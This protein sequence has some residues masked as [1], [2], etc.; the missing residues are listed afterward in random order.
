[1]QADRAAVQK[2]GEEYDEAADREQFRA[3][4]DAGKHGEQDQQQRAES[5]RAEPRHDAQTPPIQAGALQHREQH[6][7]S[8]EEREERERQLRKLTMRA[9]ARSATRRTRRT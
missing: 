3:A 4:W 5:P 6:E 2:H 9:P 1:M 7:G 8:D